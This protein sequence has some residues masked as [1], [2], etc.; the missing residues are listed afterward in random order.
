MMS[1]G[2]TPVQFVLVR[3]RHPYHH[4]SDGDLVI[5]PEQFDWHQIAW[6]PA[7]ECGHG[8]TVCPGCLASWRNDWE[9][10]GIPDRAEALARFG[11]WLADVA[12]AAADEDQDLDPAGPDIVRM[13]ERFEA[14]DLA[15][16]VEERI[17][18]RRQLAERFRCRAEL[19]DDLAIADA[20]R[21]LAETADETAAQLERES[22]Q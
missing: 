9:V 2:P 20:L 21:R 19:Q 13:A 14:E 12:E 10:K 11:E 8:E 18:F 7:S 5:D 6:L 17:A 4:T 22:E 1:A 16:P 3:I 15:S